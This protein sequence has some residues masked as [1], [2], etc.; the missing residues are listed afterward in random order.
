MFKSKSILAQWE[1]ARCQRVGHE[2]ESHIW[3]NEEKFFRNKSNKSNKLIKV[4]RRNL[5][6][7]NQTTIVTVAEIRPTS[8]PEVMNLMLTA[9]NDAVGTS[10]FDVFM[11]G[12]SFATPKKDLIGFRTISTAQITALD[13]KVGSDLGACLGIPVALQVTE[14]VE[15]RTWTDKAGKLCVQEPKINPTTQQIMSSGGQPIYRNVDLVIADE[16]INCKHTLLVADKAEVATAV[17]KATLIAES[18][19]K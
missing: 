16:A 11:K 12:A 19:G 13:I 10:E 17:S 3:T 18:I 6:N 9:K 1:S 2:F 4:K 7:T 14:S 15:P 8:N 5:M